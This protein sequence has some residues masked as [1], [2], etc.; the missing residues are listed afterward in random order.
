MFSV[1]VRTAHK[2]SVKFGFSESDLPICMTAYSTCTFLAFLGA[3]L[4]SF[5]LL[6]SASF[7]DYPVLRP[8]A[9]GSG[10][11]RY[12]MVVSIGQGAPDC[13]QQPVIL[14]NGLRLPAIEV[15]T[16]TK[17]IVS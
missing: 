3:V 6:S 16:G 9:T 7:T 2:N 15:E 10:W 14:V 12:D 17:L 1:D 8:I 13:F 11:S 5:S 4:A